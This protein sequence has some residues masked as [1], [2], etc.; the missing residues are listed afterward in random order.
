MRTAIFIKA[1]HLTTWSQLDLLDEVRLNLN[2]SIWDVR[3]IDQREGNFSKTIQLPGTK[4]NNE[5]FTDIFEID[6]D[7]NYNPALKSDVEV[8]IDNVVVF[9]GYL[10]ILKVSV[11]DSNLIGY[12]VQVVGN[13]PTLFQDIGD[14]FLSEVDLSDLN[15][16]YDFAT[17]QASWT[18]TLGEGYVY[19]LINYD[20]TIVGIRQVIDFLPA[21]FAKEYWDRIFTAAG[22]TY[23][24]AFINSNYF[25][26]LIIPYSGNGIKLTSADIQDRT[27][28]A[29]LSGFTE[30]NDLYLNYITPNF[31]TKLVVF[32]DDTTSPNFDPNGNYNTTSGRFVPVELGYYNLNVELPLV[33][34][35]LDNGVLVNSSNTFT[36][37]I[38]APN[39]FLVVGDFVNVQLDCS[40][41]LNQQ[42]GFCVNVVAKIIKNNTTVLNSAVIN[43]PQSAVVSFDEVRLR[44]AGGARFWNSCANENIVEGMTMLMDNAQPSDFKQREFL[45]SIIRM[46]NLYL[47]ADPDN[48]KNMIIEPRDTYY[49]TGAVNVLD[50]TEK[51]DESQDINIIPL[52]QLDAK[53]YEFTYRQDNDYYNTRYEKTNKEVYGKYEQAV[54]NDF[55]KD[56][57]TIA[58]GFSPTPLVG[59]SYSNII[60]PHIFQ[61]DEQSNVVS[62]KATNVRILIWGGLKNC[63]PSYLVRSEFNGDIPLTQY[64]YAGHLD[65]PYNPTED[66]CFAPPVQIFFGFNQYIQ[67]GSLQYTDSNLYN[68]YYKSL[69]DEISDK[70]SKIIQ[71]YLYLTPEDIE[72][73]SFR[74]VYT[75]NG[76]YLRLQRIIDYDPI[77]AGLTQ[78][79]FIKIKDGQP[80][81]KTTED[82]IGGTLTPIGNNEVPSIYVPG[83]PLNG[84]IKP[85]NYINLGQANVFD[86]FGVHLIVEGNNNQ[87]G[88]NVA[89]LHIIGNDNNV[90]GNSSGVVMLNCSGCVVTGDSTNVMLL[91]SSGV[92]VA[93]GVNNVMAIGLSNTTIT[94][95][96]TY[97]YNP[98]II[99][100]GSNAVT[101]DLDDPTIFS[102]NVLTIPTQYA[103]NGSFLLTGA[104][105]S[106]QINSV[107]NIPNPDFTFKKTGSITSLKFVDG[108]NIQ[109]PG[110]STFALLDGTNEDYIRFKK[111][112]TTVVKQIDVNVY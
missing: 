80:F 66:L 73:L 59:D 99:D 84:E 85:G 70:D 17:I 40:W 54:T 51:L 8:H 103:N 25:K 47:E 64:P 7:G 12:E 6:I 2:Y 106:Y 68:K 29:E 18:P 83:K 13:A 26:K 88:Q 96:G 30:T 102:S 107:V 14:K 37:N 108:A 19:P 90:Y 95:S 89:R 20:Q 71:C 76:Y 42:L 72:F 44:V 61:L 34:R 15:H 58:I 105:A 94:S 104:S 109:T 9:K 21:V 35:W 10:Q 33:S 38:Q 82:I 28:M 81:N 41:Q 56:K 60:C 87:V 63:N 52:G 36:V 46:F 45:M 49:E 78:C 69:I 86:P 53:S 77:R 50:W 31:L 65:D 1:N 91:N 74:K 79:E 112:S 22:Y 101:L 32:D 48:P 16:T 111:I 100:D 57:K 39:I 98:I 55:S 4:I 3:N 23:T 62:K 92:T 67:P 43:V 5:L 11:K 110:P 27:F 24:S 97:I 75:I 93:N